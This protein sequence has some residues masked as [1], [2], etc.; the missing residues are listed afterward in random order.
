MQEILL[1]LQD[2]LKFKAKC[3]FE[4]LKEEKLRDLADNGP[5]YLY[6]NRHRNGGGVTL[7]YE[8]KNQRMTGFYASH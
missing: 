7:R 5:I 3:P 6:E 2:F 4:F 8:V 1:Q